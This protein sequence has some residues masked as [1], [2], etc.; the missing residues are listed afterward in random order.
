MSRMLAADARELAFALQTGQC[1][2][3]LQRVDPPRCEGAVFVH[4]EA[5]DFIETIDSAAVPAADASRLR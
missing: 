2:S 3:G 1:D 4:G 5:F